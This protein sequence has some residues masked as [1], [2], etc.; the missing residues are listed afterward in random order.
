MS[1]LLDADARILIV[2][3]TGKFGTFSVKDLAQS[4]TQ[5][6]AGVAPGRSGQTIAGV[7]VFSSVAAAMTETH[8]NAAL[9]YVPA[10]VALDAVLETVEAGC[11]LIAYPGDGL[12]VLDAMEMRAAAL[13]H[14]AYLIGPN[15][16]GLISPGKAKLGFMP[17]FCYR[18]GPIG[19]ISRSGSLSYEA[20]FRLSQAGLGQT[21]VIGIG[22][23]PVRG[24]NAAEAIAL[25][26]DDP[27]TRAIIYLGEIGGSEEYALAEYAGRPDAKP[28]AALL[29]G[30]T[31]PAGKKMGHAAAMIG[32]HAESW[33]A[34]VTALDR[35]GVVI[36]R[37][38]DG[39]AS[40]AA[41]ALARAMK[42]AA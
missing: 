4:Q 32:S 15:S 28:S 37:D 41:T 25:F 26:H 30:R 29:V 40:A 11:P 16:P 8:A 36:A 19:V 20:C 7:P 38:L 6:V 27:E 21:S 13:A 31:A 3:I 1:I 35:A 39:L 9:I 24:V 34:K 10:V 2:G 12:P 14:G 17:S 23:D 5:V 18:P 33:S 22:G 42:P